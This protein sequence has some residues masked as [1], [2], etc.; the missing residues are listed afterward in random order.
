MITIR[1]GNIPGDELQPDGRRGDATGDR[2]NVLQ[3]NWPEWD[4][5]SAPMLGFT[6]RN[7]QLRTRDG[8]YTI[9]LASDPATLDFM[10]RYTPYLRDAADRTHWMAVPLQL[11]GLRRQWVDI[12]SGN[13]EYG[14]WLL[15]S[16]HINPKE[17]GVIPPDAAVTPPVAQGF[18]SKAVEVSLKFTADQPDVVIP[19]VGG[20]L[21]IS[22]DPEVV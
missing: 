3:M 12:L 5:M 21:A 19:T 1:Y 18:Y 8:S 15:V 7:H 6:E 14:E 2:E 17:Q 22:A 13:F 16:C 20:I 10:F 4:L 11:A 9:P